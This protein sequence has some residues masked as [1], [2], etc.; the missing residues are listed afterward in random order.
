MKSSSK[1]RF[2][3]IGCSRVAKKAMFSAIKDAEMAEL[4]MIGSRSKKRALECCKKFGCDSYGNYD[5][6]V[7]NDEI[8]AVYISLPVGLHE[9]WTIKAAKAGKH[10]LCE[11][12]STTSFESA[13]KMITACKKNNVRLKEGFMFRYHPQHRKVVSFIKEGLL[14]NLLM[15]HGCFGFPFPEDNDQKLKRDLGGGTLNDSA[16]YPIYAS[17]MLFNEEPISIVCKLKMDTKLGIDTKADI[18]LNYP[19]GKVA[20]IS[21]AFGAYFQSTY[22]LW[23]SKAYLS[24]ERAYAVSKDMKTSIFINR[25]DKISK[26]II[27]PEDHFKL[28]VDDFCREILKEKKSK[29]DFEKDLL[30]QARVME[31]ARI[32][33]RERRIVNIS[34]LS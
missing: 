8:D 28:M 17:R 6:V 16:A 18:L 9:E 34:E 3:V 11:K 29:K 7:R 19:N 12:S 32:S 26:I 2:G 27:E 33:N 15:F 13:K 30:S 23:G 31:V 14:G 20:F 22:G 4:G 24:M 5:D 21:S 25:D 10:V 1:I